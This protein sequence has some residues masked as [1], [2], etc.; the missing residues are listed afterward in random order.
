[1]LKPKFPFYWTNSPV[2]INSWLKWMMLVEKITT[3]PILEGFPK[4]LPTQKLLS[5]YVFSRPQDEFD[6]K[7]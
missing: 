4:K 5:V 3:I 1:L 7:V 2:K 6:G